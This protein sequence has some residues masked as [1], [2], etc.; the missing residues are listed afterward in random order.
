M[1][2]SFFCLDAM[3]AAANAARKPVSPAP[4]PPPAVSLS[5][6]VPRGE[7]VDIPLR[8]HGTRSQT[9]E[10]RIR[11]PPSAGTISAVRQTAQE[12]ATV[13][14]TAT[15]DFRVTQDHFSYAVRSKEGVSAPADVRIQIVDEPPLLIAPETLEFASLVAGTTSTREIELVNKGGGVVEGEMQVPPPWSVDGQRIYRL[16]PA[17]RR[18]YTVSF[19]PTTAGTFQ[20]EIRYTSDPARI[21]TLRGQGELAISVAPTTL[22]LAHEAKNPVRAGTFEVSNRTAQEQQ[23]RVSGSDRLRLPR[24]LHLNPGSSQTVLVQ[25]AATD[26]SEFAGEIR[27]TA[28]EH[29]AAL[30]VSAASVG[31][32]LRVTKPD[33]RF[34]QGAADGLSRAE[35]ELAN[36]GGR[37]ASIMA[38][39]TPPFTLASGSVN[40]EPGATKRL[41]ISLVTAGAA[42]QRG[43]LRIHSQSDQLEIPLEAKGNP[44]G[45]NLPHEKRAPAPFDDSPAFIRTAISSS[46][47]VETVPERINVQQ[48]TS[49]TA[50]IEWPA[51]VSPATKFTAEERRLSLQGH[52]IKIDWVGYPGFHTEKSG[53]RVIGTFTGLKP[54]QLYMM[55]VVPVLGTEGPG[56]ALVEVQFRTRPPAPNRFRITTMRVL[57]ATLLVCLGAIVWSR[58]RRRPA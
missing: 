30:V 27:L 2:V 34:E 29:A 7:S 25:L 55:R 12:S 14:Y 51:D 31:S 47:S 24:E 43:T 18:S 53:D 17:Q 16:L 46:E 56:A 26:L 13:R 58:V 52:T 35:V 15:P 28:G 48:T 36:V 21:T 40:I 23:L 9:L 38:E 50:T 20:G 8:I 19:A 39:V 42:L 22:Q 4:A 11:K 1:V 57:V 33:V 44:T 49:T 54:G 5:L 10:F 41:T 45:E 6:T 3:L 37:S 32:I